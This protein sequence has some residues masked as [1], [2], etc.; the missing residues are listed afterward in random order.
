MFTE[1]TLIDQAATMQSAAATIVKLV[2][3]L[4][5]YKEESDIG[6]LTI[7]SDGVNIMAQRADTAQAVL[8]AAQRIRAALPELE[9]L[10]LEMINAADARR[11]E[12]ADDFF[13]PESEPKTEAV[14]S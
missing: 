8:V 9:S 6:A 5:E 10:A 2:P 13:G 12:T 3:Q 14:K 11:Q 7:I 1:P 4:Q